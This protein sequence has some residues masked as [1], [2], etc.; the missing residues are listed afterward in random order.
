MSDAGLLWLFHENYGF[1]MIP[2]PMDYD[3]FIKLLLICANGDGRITPEE[4]GWIVGWVDAFRGPDSAIELSKSYDGR[5]DIASIVDAS[6]G[7]RM[8]AAAIVYYGIYAAG[9]DGELSPG[10]VAALKKV[11]AA[12]GI[13]LTKVDDL[14]DLYHEERHLRAKRLRHIYPN[15]IPFQG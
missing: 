3:S 2:P 4:R 1:K 12:L 14:I 13:T 5:G 15:G 6:P 9:A 8:S 10:E 7:V 11:A